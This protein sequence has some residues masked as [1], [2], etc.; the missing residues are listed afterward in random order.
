MHATV[1]TQLGNLQVVIPADIIGVKGAEGVIEGHD[2]RLLCRVRG[3][4][5]PQVY[6]KRANRSAT[7]AIWDKRTN[8]KRPG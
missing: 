8:S 5:P 6:W 2:A 3:F 1:R 4:P 7:I